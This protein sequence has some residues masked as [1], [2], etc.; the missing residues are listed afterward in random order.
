MTKLKQQV[1]EKHLVNFNI[2]KI[3]SIENLYFL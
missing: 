3:Q 2:I 1:P